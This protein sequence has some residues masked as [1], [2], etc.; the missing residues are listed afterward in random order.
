MTTYEVT[1]Y[2]GR[3]IST[4]VAF[5]ADQVEEIVGDLIDNGAALCEIDVVEVTR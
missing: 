3:I 4:M 2:Q 1:C 5:S